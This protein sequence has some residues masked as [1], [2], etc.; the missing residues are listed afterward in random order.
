MEYSYKTDGEEC[1]FEA[2]N[3]TEAWQVARKEANLS[4]AQIAD[5]AWLRVFDGDGNLVEE[6][7]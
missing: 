5:G 4:K 3:D 6:V 2:E 1:E 7:A